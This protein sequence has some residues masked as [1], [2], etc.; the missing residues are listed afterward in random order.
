[1]AAVGDAGEWGASS[2][3]SQMCACD[4]AVSSFVGCRARAKAEGSSSSCSAQRCAGSQSY[5]VGQVG[6]G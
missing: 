3:W 1:M 5:T 4:E 2:P 6:A